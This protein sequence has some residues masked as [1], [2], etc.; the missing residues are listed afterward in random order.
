MALVQSVLELALLV[1]ALVL[2][3]FHER[4]LLVQSVVL[5]LVEVRVLVYHGVK[6][7]VAVVAAGL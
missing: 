7:L 2:A 4:A 3:L 6:L 5:A 1:V